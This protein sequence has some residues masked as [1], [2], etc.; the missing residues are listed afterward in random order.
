MPK[1]RRK[2]RINPA[3]VEME[4]KKAEALRLVKEGF[5]LPEIARRLGYAH[6][7]GAHKLIHTALRDLVEEPREEARAVCVAR[8][9]D[10][11]TKLAPRIE[12]GDLKALG[13]ALKIEERRSRL[14]GLDAPVTVQNPQGGPAIAFLVQVPA[15]APTLADWQAQASQVIDVQPESQEDGHE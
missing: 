14:L 10:W 5:R 13:I 4:E 7:Q 11:L 2:S 12:D 15:Q 3:H 6:P 8:L 1:T 9:D